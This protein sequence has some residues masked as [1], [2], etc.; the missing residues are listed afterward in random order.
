MDPNTKSIIKS[1]AATHLHL[2]GAPGDGLHGVD[3][4]PDGAPLPGHQPVDARG[5]LGHHRAGPHLGHCLGHRVEEDLPTA[6]VAAG[7]EAPL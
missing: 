2:H 1:S 4:L 6:L 5:A 7:G 3:F